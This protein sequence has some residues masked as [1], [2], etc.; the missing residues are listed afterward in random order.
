MPH[1]KHNL[2]D[3]VPDEERRDSREREH[4]SDETYEPK[5]NVGIREPIN[6]PIHRDTKDHQGKEFENEKVDQSFGEGGHG[7]TKRVEEGSIDR[8]RR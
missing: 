7:D 8:K 4:S 3:R 5:G 1:T 2:K 6:G